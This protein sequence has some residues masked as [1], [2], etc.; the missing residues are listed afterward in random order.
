[1]TASVLSLPRHGSLSFAHTQ[2]PVRVG[3]CIS[4]HISLHLPI[5]PYISQYLPLSPHISATSPPN[6]VGEAFA[7]GEELRYLY[8]APASPSS[9]RAVRDGFRFTACDPSGALGF[10]V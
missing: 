1:M 10:G 7:L 8:P 6:Q 4:P 9:A 2:A 5:S 3:T